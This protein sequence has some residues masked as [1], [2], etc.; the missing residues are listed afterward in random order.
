MSDLQLPVRQPS[1]LPLPALP[2][3]TI[4]V[5]TDFSAHATAVEGI[6]AG[7][8]RQSMARLVLVH[9]FVQSEYARAAQL[10]PA[11]QE[12]ILFPAAER[13]SH[14][15]QARCQSLREAGTDV[16]FAFL[17]HSSASE[18]IRELAQE[19]RAD[20]I[21]I[22]THGRT[23]LPQYVLGSVAEGV[24]R[25]APCS[26]LTIHSPRWPYHQGP[27]LGPTDFSQTSRAALGYAG[28]LAWLKHSKLEVV[29]VFDG[30]PAGSS[31]PFFA[32]EELEKWCRSARRTAQEKVAELAREA[33][34]DG[35]KVEARLLE[36]PPA[37]T[38]VAEAE[39]IHASVI[40]LA[41]SKEEPWRKALLGSTAERVVRLA[42]CPVLIVR[43]G[44]EETAGAAPV[45]T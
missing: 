15:L 19:K 44:A 18:G 16:E 1:R 34:H 2:L 36:G 27:V 10:D 3:R 25:S 41:S 26:V 40:V 13:P 45:A 42:N 17:G 30:A 4:L 7:L 21:V 32:N 20:L 24:V 14:L 31:L 5:A 39:S 29:H 43:P 38:I 37:Q 22:G 6:A 8:A 35:L 23:G 11:L 28:E 12:E 33:E 9:V